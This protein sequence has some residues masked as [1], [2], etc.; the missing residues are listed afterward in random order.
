MTGGFI[1]GFLNDG[2]SM[3]PIRI[4][5]QR[6]RRSSWKSK[7]QCRRRRDFFS[8]SQMGKYMKIWWY[9]WDDIR[10]MGLINDY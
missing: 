4:K 6:R 7:K 2:Y 5:K 10:H 8:S 3:I 9:P 1:A